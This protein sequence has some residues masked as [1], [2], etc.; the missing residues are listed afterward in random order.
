MMKFRDIY[1]SLASVLQ[2]EKIEQHKSELDF[3]H[4]KKSKLFTSK[5]KIGS[6]VRIFPSFEKHI[7]MMHIEI[8]R[9]I[10]KNKESNNVAVAHHMFSHG[11]ASM[12]KYMD[13]NPKIKNIIF[14]GE[15]AT[16]EKLYDRMVNVAKK[17]LSHKYDFSKDGYYYNVLR[18]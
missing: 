13:I 1:E 17:H 5:S 14:S 11:I 15:T 2:P 4:D 12:D 8:D 7:A 6:E 3:T 18:K 9:N 10:K 16:H